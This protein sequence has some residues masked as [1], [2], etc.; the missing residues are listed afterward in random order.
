MRSIITPDKY[1]DL[2]YEELINLACL[3]EWQDI[4]PEHNIYIDLDYDRKRAPLTIPVS[5]V[6]TDFSD[7][8]D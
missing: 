4:S 1:S 8:V 3:T 5:V 6:A 7:V 2:V